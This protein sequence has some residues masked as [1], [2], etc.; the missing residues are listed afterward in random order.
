MHWPGITPEDKNPRTA[1]GASQERPNARVPISQMRPDALPP[2]PFKA[3]KEP[4]QYGRTFKTT[5][6][7]ALRWQ[8]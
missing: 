8:G 2:S 7:R 3:L 1:R 5:M 6:W 4:D